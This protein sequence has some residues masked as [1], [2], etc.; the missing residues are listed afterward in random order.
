MTM[1]AASRSPKTTLGEGLALPAFVEQAWNEHAEQPREVATALRE[2]ARSLALAAPAESAQDQA[3]AEAVLGASRLAEHVLLAHLDDAEGLRAW[4]DLVPP[5]PATEAAL[6]RPRWLLAMLADPATPP[7]SDDKARYGAL[8]NLWAV[9]VARGHAAQALEMLTREQPSALAH[10]DAATR[11]ALAATCNNLTV[12]LRLGP[13]GDAARDALMLA[14]AEA[15]RA[16]WTSAGTWVN[17]ERAEYQLA[18]CHAVLGDGRRA[19]QHAR[20]CLAAVEAHR[21]EAQA[22]AFETFFAH[23]ALLWAHRAAR[24]EPSAAAERQ[25]MADRLAE[26]GDAGARAWAEQALRA[27]DAGGGR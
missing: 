27:A 2:R 7:L 16:L 23:E 6:R 19:L 8:Q 20:A 26:I 13:R 10:P 25:Q 22:D 12:E 1:P 3:Q 17:A 9:W 4:L 24:D 5:S 11:R 14:A 21:G 18:R 15:S